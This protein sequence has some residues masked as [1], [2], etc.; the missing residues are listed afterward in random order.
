[1]G[2]VDD[3]AGEASTIARGGARSPAGEPIRGAA[4]WSSP[5]EPVTGVT[6]HDAGEVDG[7][8]W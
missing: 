7:Q 5:R 1:M 2:R 3:T 4:P 8:Y 6:V